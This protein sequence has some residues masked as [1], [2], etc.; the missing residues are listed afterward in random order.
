MG[1]PYL[2]PIQ[3][4]GVLRI[5]IPLKNP[6]PWPGSNPQPLGPVADTLTTTPPRRLRSD[7]LTMV[8]NFLTPMHAIFPTNRIFRPFVAL[9]FLRFECSLQRIVPCC[10]QSMLFPE[11]ETPDFTLIQNCG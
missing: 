4:E 8:L 11:V 3:E 10:A 5:F 6:S 1:R 9:C 7:L 2:L